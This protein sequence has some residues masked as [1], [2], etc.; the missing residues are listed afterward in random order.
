MAF[1]PKQEYLITEDKIHLKDFFD[2]REDYITRPPYQRKSVWALKKQQSLFDSLFR[3]FYVPR[4]VVREVRLSQDRTVRE[5]IDGQQRITAVQDF[6]D[7]KFKLPASLTD[8][9]PD[10]ANKY[11][12]DLTTE[13]R[14]F[15]DKELVINADIVKNIDDP[16]NPEHQ[17]VATEIFWRLQQGEQLNFMEIAHAKLS[18]L[19]RNFI[20][21]Y[22]DDET[23]DYENYIPID[24][25]PNK[26]KFFQI[27]ERSNN[28]MEHLTLMTRFLIIEE[29][30]GYV[31][32]K[33]TA[34]TEFIEKF[35]DK[36]GVGNYSFE[37]NEIAKNCIRNLNL[38]Y[39]IFKNDSMFDE[40]N[41]IKELSREYLIISFYLLIRH[42]KKH[43]AIGDTEKKLINKFF[44]AFYERWKKGEQDDLDINI[45]SN[46]RQ[47]SQNNLQERDII[48]RQ[49]FFEYLKTQNVSLA[50]LDNK[51]LFNEQEKIIIYRR[52]KGLCQQCLK[53]GKPENEAQVTWT[54]YQADHIFPYA[55]G[56]QST[57]D[58]AQVLCAYHNVRKSSTV[59]IN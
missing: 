43:Y 50:L 54:Q 25:N 29:A 9:H 24:E 16:K 31:E 57:I 18:S 19:S 3:R 11:F 36:D 10:L 26:H 52:D 48:L 15:I 28:R 59:T 20:V 5:I 17:R 4:L 12:S 49:I 38:F 22:S 27:I 32:L 35:D 51:R 39:D 40:E 44:F 21:K 2:Y 34:V 7:N 41:G 1:N 56:G 47:Q 53:E 55:K 6:F 58:N 23:F 46:N 33:D 30:N 13:L 42:L 45:F 8:I 37:N 14:K